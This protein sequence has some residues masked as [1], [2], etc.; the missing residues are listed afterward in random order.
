M[1]KLF[2]GREQEARRSLVWL[3]G[4]DQK[5]IDYEI[6]NIK[7]ALR[8]KEENR[9]TVKGLLEKSILKPFLIALTMFVFLNL[10]G[11]NIMIFYCNAI[12]K[13][14]GSSI[15]DKVAAIIVGIVLLGSSF[16]AIVV[17]SK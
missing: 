4:T 12:F 15:S 1:I 5:C 7:R 2:P 16:V 11:L 3:H 10:S 14:S 9:V 8:D 6:L 13:Y 17:I